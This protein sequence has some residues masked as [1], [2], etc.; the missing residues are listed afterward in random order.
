LAQKQGKDLCAIICDDNG[1]RYTNFMNK[2]GN[3]IVR[4]YGCTIMPEA[5][6]IAS[7]DELQPN[8][9]IF[10]HAPVTDAVANW[11][12]TQEERI[13]HVYAQGESNVR[14]NFVSA[15]KM[16]NVL[17]SKKFS[18]NDKVT[19]YASDSTGFFIP[20]DPDYLATL[21]PKAAELYLDYFFFQKLKA[22]G[23]P[24]DN[25]TLADQL[26][27]NTG[28]P[29]GRAGNGIFFRLGLIKKL[30]EEGEGYMPPQ[31]SPELIEDLG[32]IDTALQNSYRVKGGGSNESTVTNLRDLL[33][34]TN[35]YCDYSKFLI[36]DPRG[37]LLPDM[38]NIPTPINPTPNLPVYQPR[39]GVREEVRLMFDPAITKTT[40]LFDFA[41][42]AYAKMTATPPPNFSY[43]GNPP[44]GDTLDKLRAAL[45][46]SLNDFNAR[47]TPPGAA[48][49]NGG[50]KSRRRRRKHRKTRR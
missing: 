44:Q 19:F 33:W 40:N 20:Y 48:M 43:P 5:A 14:A 4:C 34:L 49:V 28:G 47:L 11:L 31:N 25:V 7:L 16:W 18:D 6:L 35:K 9:T 46:A 42:A 21:Q 36:R 30:R 2:Y 32:E 37:I 41:S 17:N 10:I 29:G 8:T 22:F 45:F 27:S 1:K 3:D 38:G 13:F 50:R 15:Q 26:F 24:A 39:D 12:Y 23:L